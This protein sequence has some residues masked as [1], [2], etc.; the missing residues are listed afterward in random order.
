MNI[1]MFPK[2]LIPNLAVVGLALG[3]AACLAAK[4]EEPPGLA[5]ATRLFYRLDF[6]AAAQHLEGTLK[7]HPDS[8]PSRILLARIQAAKGEPDQAFREL[9][10]VLQKDETQVDALFYLAQLSAFLS[11]IQFDHLYALDAD[12]YRVHQLMAESHLKQDDPESAEKEFHAALR[13]N[14]RSVEILNALGDLERSQYRFD[15]AESHYRKAVR[16]RPNDYDSSYGLGAVLLYRQEPEKAVYY[17]RRAVQIDPNSPAAL[18]ALGDAQLRA[19][20]FTSAIEELKL[21]LKLRPD[22]RQAYTLLGT[23]LMRSG[24]SAEAQAAFK[25][26]RE[27]TQQEL[28]RGQ[29][30]VGRD[31]AAPRPKAND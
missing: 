23:A 10:R 9:Q 15:E 13:A 26:A 17:L 16:L 22:M 21:A 12:S 1:Q 6:E 27:L 2:R 7:T 28:R 19:K 4:A 3:L 14:P 31:Q 11:Q 18:L 5:E 8:I 20:N 25:K 24:N 29:E 30:I